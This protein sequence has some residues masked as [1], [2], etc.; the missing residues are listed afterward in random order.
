MLKWFRAI[1][2][3]EDRF[4][5][6]FERHSQTLVAG[7]QSLRSALDGGQLLPQRLQAVMEQEQAADDVTREVLLSVRRSFITPF[8]R[9]DIK[10]LITSMDDAID[11]MQT[12]AKIILLYKVTTFEPEMQ[13]MADCIVQ[14]SGLV[15]QAVP[16]LRV[17]AKNSAQLASLTE[18]ISKVE[19]QADDI[20][21][22]GLQRMFEAAGPQDS[23]AFWVHTQILHHLEEAVDRLDDVANKIHGVVI[24]HV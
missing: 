8:D 19:G 22:G 16:L 3:K 5:D 12:T 23:L 7:A 9:G 20:H 10:D 2:P 17:V 21:D 15:R 14:A 6:L 1:M 11:Q 24:E 13:Q 18:Q 4:F